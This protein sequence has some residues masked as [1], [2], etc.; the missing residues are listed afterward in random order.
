MGET[1][2]LGTPSGQLH[3]R[4][5][6]HDRALGAAH[7]D[8]GGQPALPIQ[9]HRQFLQRLAHPGHSLAA[10][11]GSAQLLDGGAAVD[12]RL[13]PA[14]VMLVQRD[15]KRLAQDAGIHD[16]GVQPQR[17]QPVAQIADLS[18]FGVQRSDDE[19]CFSHRNALQAVMEATDPASQVAA[20]LELT[21]QGVSSCHASI[22]RQVTPVYLLT[23]L[24]A[25]S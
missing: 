7:A 12:G 3:H 8:D 13:R 25:Y 19:N 24:H 22:W 14:D 16:G 21:S 9:L 17:L 1:S 10:A 11:A 15:A 4:R 18:A 5:R 6:A 20:R 23:F 2:T